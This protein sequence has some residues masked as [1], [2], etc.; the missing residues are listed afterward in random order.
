MCAPDDLPHSPPRPPQSKRCW[1][2]RAA[3]RSPSRPP[4]RP[5]CPTTRGSRMPRMSRREN[6]SRRS[7][8][9]VHAPL[10]WRV[11][12]ASGPC[13]GSVHNNLGGQQRNPISTAGSRRNVKHVA[14]DHRGQRAAPL[15]RGVAGAL[16][17]AGGA[18]VQR[19]RADG[20]E[21]WLRSGTSL[22]M[23][24]IVVVS[25]ASP[26]RGHT[27]ARLTI[28]VGFHSPRLPFPQ[29]STS[30]TCHHQ[31]TRSL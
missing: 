20:E 15:R 19:R 27:S 6:L 18:R 9:P 23:C 17:H 26:H 8:T 1:R 14:R 31:Y 16:P 24:P 7:P 13:V 29:R 10:G 12:A 28:P 2:P 5:P 21:V 25:C 11:I 3:E 30:W 4:C 22:T